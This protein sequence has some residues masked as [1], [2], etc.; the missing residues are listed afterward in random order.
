MKRASLA[1]AALLAAACPPAFA[2]ELP[3]AGARFNLPV[4]SVRQLRFGATLRQQ[5][6]FSCGSAALATLLTYHYGRPVSEQRVFEHMYLNGDQNKIRKEGFSMLDMQRFLA[7]HGLRGD[8]FELPLDKLAAA[9]LPAIVL[10]SERG[11]HHFV[12]IKG[13]A[14][15]RVLVGDPSSGARA[16]PRAAFETIWLGKLL[17][18]IHGD[19]GVAGFNA[20]ADWRAAPAAPL[21]IGI[22][23]DAPMLPVMPKLGPGDF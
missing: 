5:F 15:G 13:I 2:L 7:A 11:Y 22:G 16:M 12:V 20:A 6:D 19:S 9:R 3:L 18:V 8:G 4:A 23:R 10:V 1:A 21:E 17:F 14:N